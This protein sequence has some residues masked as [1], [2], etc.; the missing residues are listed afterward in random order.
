[1]RQRRRTTW[2]HGIAALV[3]S[4]WLAAGPAVAA[5]ALF[6]DVPGIPGEATFPPAAG[7][8]QALSFQWN[9]HQ[10]KVT[11]YG[12]AGVC[13]A[14]RAKPVFDAVCV[15]KH[16]DKASPKLFLAAAQGTHFAKVTISLFDLAQ[17]SNPALNV[18]ELSSVFVS[19]VETKQQAGDDFLIEQVCFNGDEVKFTVNI[20][21]AAGGPVD[22]VTAA[23]NTCLRNVP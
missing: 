23:F 1:M 3:V 7:Q 14:G 22:T 13:S 20:P 11:R 16:V 5:T 6:V 9:I 19:T 8:I 4:G 21:S 2:R 18:Y 10:G 15:L 12:T 17:P